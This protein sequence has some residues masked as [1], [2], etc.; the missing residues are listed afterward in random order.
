MCAIAAGILGGL[1]TATA[2]AHSTKIERLHEAWQA[3]IAKASV[4]AKGCFTASYP[5][6]VWRQVPCRKAPHI[7]FVPRGAMSGGRQTVG[8]GTDYAAASTNLISAATGSFPVVQNLVSE[9]GA[10]GANDFSLQINSNFMPGGRGCA[11]ATVPTTCKAWQQFVFANG[12]HM[13][14]MQYWLIHYDATCPAGWN[15]QIDGSGNDCWI[16]GNAVFVGFG[17]DIPVTDLPKMRLRGSAKAG[18][19]D[20]LKLVDGT[21]AWSIT[22]EDSFLNLANRWR[23]TE[24]NVLGDGNGTAATFNAGTVLKVTIHL[25][26]G[27]TTKPRCLAGAGTTGETNNLTLGRCGRAA[28]S[29]P[30]IRFFE[31]N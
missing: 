8:N 31:S 15:T 7:P 10:L 4:P 2:Q 24:F 27:L 9:T 28:G 18:G 12:A 22:G 25:T 20:T 13:A 14:F 17:T 19:L 21:Q 23:E 29:S 30:A 26:N 6:V 11:G 16:S 3:A 1:C 5:A